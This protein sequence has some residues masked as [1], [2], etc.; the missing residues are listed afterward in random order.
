M[1]K[2]QDDKIKS[3]EENGALNR[4]PH[5]VEDELF[6]EGDFFDPHDLMQ[7]K[8]EMVR[9]VEKD[10]W[11]V[12]RAS[13]AFGYSRP[14]FYEVQKAIKKEGLPGLIP[15]KRGPKTPHKLTENVMQFV[16]EQKN[17]KNITR[18]SELANLIKK[19]F[20]FTIH[21]RSIERTLEKKK[22]SRSDGKE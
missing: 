2:K 9:R 12:A 18:A 21:P 20:G 3:L 15:C 4:A 8:Y 17:E 22:Q 1:N 14:F 5:A 7:V 6:K 11:K 19:H 10:N 16:E 13:K